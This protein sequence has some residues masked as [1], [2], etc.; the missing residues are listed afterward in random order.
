MVLFVLNVLAAVCFLCGALL[1]LEAMRAYRATPAVFDPHPSPATMQVACA[2]NRRL[3]GRMVL[4]ML[5]LTVAGALRA[6]TVLQP[7]AC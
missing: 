3:L 7:G 6:I 4:G 1:F 2:A 5:F